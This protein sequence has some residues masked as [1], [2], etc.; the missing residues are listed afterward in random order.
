MVQAT[1]RVSP[2]SASGL[3]VQ[4][5]S[6][7]RGGNL[8]LPGNALNRAR[9]DWWGLTNPVGPLLAATSGQSP[10]G[11]FVR[12]GENRGYQESQPV[13]IVRQE[14]FCGCHFGNLAEIGAKRSDDRRIFAFDGLSV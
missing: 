1:R 14:R 8:R 10:A 5:A 9:G 2:L 4:P 6:G 13:P 3:K 12:D 11:F 7:Y